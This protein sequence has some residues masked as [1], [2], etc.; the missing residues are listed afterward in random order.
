MRLI[1]LLVITCTLLVPVSVRADGQADEA[2]LQFQIGADAYKKGD[3]TTALEH[4]LASNRL[5]PNR[6]VMFNIARAYEQLQHYPEAYRYYVD[7]LRG[8][9]DPTTTK[10][11]EAALDRMAPKVAAGDVDVQPQGATVFIDRKDPGSVGTSPARLGLLAGKYKIIVEAPGYEAWETQID[12]KVGERQK[13]THELDRILGTLEIAG[14]A[15]TEVRLDDEAAPIACITPCKLDVPPGTHVLHFRARGAAIAPRPVVVEAKKSVKITPEVVQLTGS[16][17]VS[18]DEANALV[19]IDGEPRGFTPAVIANV[20]IGHRKVRVTLSGYEP[21]ERDIDV[22]A[23]VQ[24]DLRDLPMSTLRQVSAASRSTELIEDAPASVSIISA[25]ELEA[26]AYPTVLEALRGTR[27]VSPTYDSIYGNITVRGLGQPNDYTNRLLVLSD[28]MTLNE[29]VLYQPF[30]HYDGRSDLGDVDR[31]EIVRG[32]GSVL[33]GTGAESGVINLV[34]R[35]RDE[36]SS[37]Q[38]GISSYDNAVARGRLAVTYRNKNNWGFWASMAATHSDGRQVDLKFADDPTVD[39]TATSHPIDGFDAFH[40]YTTT[41]KLWWHDL[42]L[43]YF[44]TARELHIPTGSFGSIL[45]DANDKYVDRRGLLELKYEPQLSKTTDLLVRAYTN[46]NYFHLD[47]LFANTTASGADYKQPYQET[48]PTYWSGAEARLRWQLSKQLRLSVGGEVVVDNQVELH[49]SQADE[50][51]TVTPIM[52]VSAPY[53]VFAAYANAEYRPSKKL[54]FNAGLRIDHWQLTHDA[55]DVEG[56]IVP[57]QDFTSVNPRVA[58]IAKPTT[59]DIIK[60]MAGRAF[61]APTTYE[62]YYNDGGATQVSSHCCSANGLQP[63]TVYSGELEYTHNLTRDWSV[64][65]S[66]Y[67]TYASNIVESVPVPQ[68]TI[69]MHNAGNP[70][71]SWADGVE[72]YANSSTPINLAG[73]DLE[74]RKEWRS[75]TMFLATYGLLLARYTDNSVGNTHVPN[76]PTQYASIRGVTP[77]VPNLINGAVRLTFE[78]ARRSSRN[79]DVNSPR[80]IIA[81]VVL[82]GRLQHYH[83]KYAMGVYNLF[84]WQFALPANPFPVENMPQAGRSLMFNL[85]YTQELATAHN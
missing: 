53:T 23:S 44:Y 28:G 58:V 61:R 57:T 26:F 80:A 73:L 78:D 35:G 39:K 4:F 8:E 47:Y 74:A 46:Y 40:T 76:A 25:Q 18:S 29:N 2:D 81:D 3:F 50:T 65:A 71:F 45:N 10:A 24:S 30:L 84:N 20:P 62:Y 56:A 82:S 13:V 55:R 22:K 43:Q 70:A 77:L 16:I 48:Y 51:G 5:V 7:A 49:S 1:F 15:G 9:S 75:G 32:P 72:S 59:D 36:P 11:I 38:G 79:D 41:G 31:I 19:E 68:S 34:M 64:L 67:D 85:L 27:G 37:V 21:V 60:L 17:L 52:N 83:L 66:L 42:T 69:D 14:T 33:Y 54:I 63:E 12:A 6:N